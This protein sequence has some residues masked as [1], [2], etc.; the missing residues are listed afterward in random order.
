MLG[1]FSQFTRRQTT[2]FEK[3]VRD[4]SKIMAAIDRINSTVGT[5]KLAATGVDQKWATRREP[6]FTGVH[7]TMAGYS[8]GEMN[9]GIKFFK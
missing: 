8:A 6:A 7:N 9:G 3:P 1:D 2:L 5:I 4:N